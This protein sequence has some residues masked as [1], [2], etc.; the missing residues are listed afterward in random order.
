M[1]ND[2][3]IIQAADIGPDDC[4][5]TN[6]QIGTA[7]EATMRKTLMSVDKGENRRCCKSS[8]RVARRSDARPLDVSDKP[9]VISVKA[10][11]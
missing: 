8:G 1:T 5:A 7:V 11:T 9:Q 10:F 4:I 2:T 3:L 6:R